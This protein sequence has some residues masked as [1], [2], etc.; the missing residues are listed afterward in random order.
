MALHRRRRARVIACLVGIGLATAPWS[1]MASS[2]VPTESNSTEGSTNN[3][4]PFGCAG[5]N[6]PSQRYQQVYRGADVGAGVITELR[7][8]QDFEAAAFPPTIEP[9]VTITLSSTPTGPDD[10]SATFADNVGADAT[11]VFAGDLTLSSAASTRVP[12]PFDIVVPLTTPFTFDPNSGGNLLL[13]VRIANCVTTL[14][15]FDS[16]FA[17]GNGVARAFTSSFSNVDSPTASLVTHDGLVTEF[18]M[19]G[20][21]CGNGIV[22]GGEACEPILACE[23]G[24]CD[25]SQGGCCT[26]TCTMASAGTVCRPPAYDCD[27]PEVCTGLS[28][29]C[30]ADAPAPAGTPCS[31]DG[32]VCTTDQCDAAGTCVHTFPAVAGC[33]PAATRRAPVTLVSGPEAKISWKWRG[34]ITDRFDF[35][36]PTSTSDLTLCIGTT[37]GDLLLDAVVPHGGLCRGVPCWIPKPDGYD[38]KNLDRTPDGLERITLRSSP[39]PDRARLK[40]KGRG[41]NLT[42]V[43]PPYTAPLRVRLVR[44]D[45]PGTCWEG[46]YGSALRN[47]TTTFKAQSD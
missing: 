45:D 41:P 34:T 33:V 29:G 15:Q 4:F 13:D 22:E 35:G 38:Y 27:A 8:R 19:G 3:R 39:V 40:V 37:S 11:V 7:F 25:L 20:I 6:I 18:V 28:F 21:A 5:A 36:P 23:G 46:A 9:G 30:P 32:K 47:D 16:D 2:V 14:V 12:R 43:G 1:G 17:S 42:L 31:D 26:D 24:P 10:L 44:T